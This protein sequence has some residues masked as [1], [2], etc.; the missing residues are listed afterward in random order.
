MSELNVV[1][2][3]DNRQMLSVLD[4]MLEEE[5]GFHVVGKADNGKDAY[6]MIMETK[7]DLVLIDVIM[8]MLDG[9]SVMDQVKRDLPAET[10]PPFIVLTAAGSEEVISDAFRRGASYYIMK[11]FDQA[12]VMDKIRRIS[13][14]VARISGSD[15]M[16]MVGPYV[17]KEE[18]M[19]QNLETDVTKILHEIGIPAH[20]KGYQY[21][22]D[23]I[24][25]SVKEDDTLISVT[26]ILYPMIAKRHNTTSSRVERAIRHAIEVTWERGRLD[27]ICELFGYTVSSGKGKPTNSEFIALVADKIRLDYKNI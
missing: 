17:N 6:A 18:Y 15:G 4:H 16:K 1:I 14:G 25:M 7:P 26:K 12:V 20:I 2:A 19:E 21:L 24:V 9:L 27:S 3:E 8:P 11:P 23:A 10:A 22:R 13:R 5:K